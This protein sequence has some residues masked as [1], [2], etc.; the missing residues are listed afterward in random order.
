MGDLGFL[1]FGLFVVLIINGFRTCIRAQ[2]LAKGDPS[3]LNLGQMAMAI[4]GA[5]VVY[6]IGG[7][8][9]SHQYLEM[10]WHMLALSIATDRLVR[11]RVTSQVR[12]ETSGVAV[13]TW[14]G[15]IAVAGPIRAARPVSAAGSTF[16]RLSE[17]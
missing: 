14:L 2:R 8:F 17:R 12:T 9:V 10:H 16:H 5:L 4:E 1:G 15:G 13:P 6:C 11:E 7:S 3:L